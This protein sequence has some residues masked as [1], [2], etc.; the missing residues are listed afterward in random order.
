MGPYPLRIRPRCGRMDRDP[1]CGMDHHHQ[2]PRNDQESARRPCGRGPTRGRGARL[3]RGG[4]AV[5]G[6]LGRHAHGGVGRRHRV[7]RAIQ[8]ARQPDRA[9]QSRAATGARRHIARRDRHR[10]CHRFRRI[11]RGAAG[12]RRCAAHRR[13]AQRGQ[14]PLHHRAGGPGGARLRAARVAGR[15]RA[16]R[17]HAAVR[18]GHA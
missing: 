1:A 16:G 7:L 2:H 12:D 4:A 6:G 15:D 9:H 3:H 8:G 14:R 5:L 17:W 18:L 13:D 10:R 11:P